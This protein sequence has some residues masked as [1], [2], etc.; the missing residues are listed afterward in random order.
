[1]QHGMYVKIIN[2]LVQNRSKNLKKGKGGVEFSKVWRG[3]E[4]RVA[5]RL[6]LTGQLANAT[7][8]LTS[9]EICTQSASIY[10][11]KCRYH[12]C[13]SVLSNELLVVRTC[14]FCHVT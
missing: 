3:T 11:S 13:A 4:V 9:P 8:H 5:V 2:S 7:S 12:M 10:L 1:M 6:Q 14:V